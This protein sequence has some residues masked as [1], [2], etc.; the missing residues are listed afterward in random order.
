MVARTKLAALQPQ[1]LLDLLQRHQTQ[2]QQQQTQGESR[3]KAAPDPRL[4]S[5]LVAQLQSLVAA[6]EAPAASDAA[7]PSG[8][9]LVGLRAGLPRALVGAP[10]LGGVLRYKKKMMLWSVPAKPTGAAPAASA[11]AADA[12]MADAAAPT[13]AAASEGG[14]GYCM[15]TFVIRNGL[16]ALGLGLQT[17]LG[18]VSNLSRS[19]RL[20]PKQAAQVRGCGGVGTLSPSVPANTAPPFHLPLTL[21]KYL[22]QTPPHH[23]SIQ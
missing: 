4:L 8:S 6:A 5:K 23:I 7:G 12:P 14:M 9:A 1:D 19:W 17:Y 10:D 20:A 11:P 2:Q 3:A 16:K 13:A 22:P 18:Y 15:M 21:G